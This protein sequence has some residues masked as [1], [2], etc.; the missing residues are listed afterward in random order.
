METDCLKP[1]VAFSVPRSPDSDKTALVNDPPLRQCETCVIVPVRNEAALVEQT[2]AALIDQVDLQGQPIDPR[3]YE[4]IVL[5]NNC[6]DESAAIARRFARRHPD[7]VLHVVE[8]AL[9]PAE[10]Y[11]GRVRQLLMD[12]ADRRLRS[13]GRRRGIIA[14]TDGDSQVAQTWIAATQWEI[15]R[16]ADAVGGRIIT[17]CASRAALDAHARLCHLREVGY[18][19]LIAELEDYLDPDPF[20]RYPRHYQHY[21]ASFAV[22][23]DAYQLAGGMPAVR[24]PEDVA[25][26]E[27]L[28]RVD[29]RFRHSPLVQVTTSARPIGRV[30]NGLSNQLSQWSA[31][32]E[33]QLPFLVESAEAIVDRLQT[34]SA[35]RKLWHLFQSD[36]PSSQSIAW[37]AQSLGITIERLV[38]DL[39]HSPSF[40]RLCERVQQSQL[41]NENRLRALVP[42]QH[43]I[44]DLRSRLHL[45]RSERAIA[46]APHW[47]YLSTPSTSGL[48]SHASPVLLRPLQ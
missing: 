33:Q 32:G 20:D 24:T 48:L 26:Y 2:L 1:P 22:T 5:A 45:L 21:G 46:T 38:N 31:M 28:R 40:G 37:V 44:A 4:V 19:S 12:E 34:R 10:A 18:R 35:L 30:Q 29:A 17:H 36:S 3:R 6:T 27:A 14:S 43:A 39:F 7:A 15:D 16:G 47:G 13:I 23:A 42:I 25:F 9:P 11:I 41:P 8:R